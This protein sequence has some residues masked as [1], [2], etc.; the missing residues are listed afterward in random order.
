MSESN[1]VTNSG[2]KHNLHEMWDKI[3]SRNDQ[4]SIWPW[5]DLVGTVM[6]NA[7]PTSDNFRVLELGCGAGANIPFFLSLGV[8]YYSIDASEVVIS[9]LREKYP[10]LE[11]NLFAGDFTRALPS[12]EFDLIFDRGSTVCNKTETIKKCIENCYDQ[13]K[14]NGK[15]IGIDW[16]STKHSSFFLGEVE[17]DWTRVNISS[18]PFADVYR[19]HFSSKL[20]LYELFKRFYFQELKHKTIES[21]FDSDH[22]IVASWNF[23]AVKK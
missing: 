15:Y 1:C 23:A 19:M 21:E 4:N 7:R 18:G 16:F 20:H 22:Q 6:R 5:S 10:Q 3:Y 12:G 13:L 8:E 14:P 11:T 9:R 17:D 2:A